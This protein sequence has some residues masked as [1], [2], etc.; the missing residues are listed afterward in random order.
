MNRASSRSVGPEAHGHVIVLNIVTGDGSRFWVRRARKYIRTHHLTHFP[1]TSLAN[2]APTYTTTLFH[3]LSA[4]IMHPIYI[5][6]CALGLASTVLGR[7]ASPEGLVHAEE[8]LTNSA[9]LRRGLPPKAP[10][11]LFDPS[12]AA[13]AYNTSSNHSIRFSDPLWLM[14][15]LQE[16]NGPLP[17]QEQSSPAT[18]PKLLAVPP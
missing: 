17:H 18:I 2:V 8:E 15:L 12:K 6:F 4:P 14:Q 11:H 9:R 13:S 10:R 16:Q 7:V 5:L 1:A 3:I